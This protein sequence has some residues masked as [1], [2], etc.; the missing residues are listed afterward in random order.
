MFCAAIEA[1]DK[2]YIRDG[3]RKHRESQVKFNLVNSRL[4]QV[5][6]MWTENP[7]AAITVQL[8]H[9]NLTSQQG[10]Q[11]NHSLHQLAQPQTTNNHQGACL[12][13]TITDEEKAQL[14]ANTLKYPHHPST[15]EGHTAY[16]EQ[17]CT[18]KAAHGENTTINMLTP[19]PDPNHENLVSYNNH[20]V[21]STTVMH[22]DIINLYH[23][24]HPKITK[25]AAM[26]EEVP[27]IHNIQI[28]GPKGEVIQVRALF[29]GGT[30][31]GAMCTSIFHKVQHCLGN[32]APLKHLLWIANGV[33][34]P[35]KR[36]WEGPIK[37]GNVMANG[38]FEVFNSYG[39]WGF[40]FSKPL[41]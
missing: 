37:L 6:H 26:E 39:G 19:F 14:S 34:E 1:V 18:W 9:V 30:M 24:D 23:A 16:F 22:S 32:S 15:A 13:G 27:F 36:Q 31:V 2:A 10:A 21:S 29:D 11:T 17:L 8:D 41:L 38:Q 7:V 33:I 12:M 28:L 35:S 25:S 3:I 20:D 5:E 40:L 4:S